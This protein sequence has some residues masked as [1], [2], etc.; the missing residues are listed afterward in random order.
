M[1]RERF[2]KNVRLFFMNNRQ[3]YVVFMMLG[4]YKFVY[5]CFY[6]Y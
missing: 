2:N 3:K 4:N 6:P 1:L 5:F